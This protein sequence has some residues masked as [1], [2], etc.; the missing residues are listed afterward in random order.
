MIVKT[1]K[2]VGGID[3]CL[4]IIDQRK[5]P[6]EYKIIRCSNVKQLYDAIKTLAVRRAGNRGSRGVW[7]GFELAGHIGKHIA[8]TIAYR[9]ETELQILGE[10]QAHGGQLAMGD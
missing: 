10:Q 4:E 5:L 3:G 9:F 2:W 8:E 6:G 1:L 7:G